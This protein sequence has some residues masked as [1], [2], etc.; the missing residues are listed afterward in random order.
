MKKSKIYKITAK[1]LGREANL[2]DWEQLSAL[3][4]EGKNASSF[5]DFVKIQYLTK[6]S[7]AHYDIKNA[8]KT[9]NRKLKK[10]ERIRS[11]YKKMT[12]AAVIAIIFGISFYKLTT[13]QEKGVLDASTTKVIEIDPGSNKAILTL[14]NGN[15]VVLEKGKEYTSKKMKSNGTELKYVP[16]NNAVNHKEKPIYNFLTVPKGGQFFV[17]LSDGTSVWLNSDSKLKYP[18]EFV[19]GEKRIVE[20]VYGEA[21]FKVSPS[22]QHQGA[23]FSVINNSHEVSVLGTEFNMKVYTNDDTAL[24]TLVEG[25]VKI[26]KDGSEKI[27]NPD[28]QARI[29]RLSN[30]VEVVKVDASRETSWIRGLFTFDEEPLEDIM[31]TLSRWYNIEVV[32]ESSTKRKL[33]FTGVLERAEAIT[34]ILKLIEDTSMRKVKF[35]IKN[36]TIII[37]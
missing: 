32:F 26:H 18:E 24:T 20:L 31:K 16:A 12:M 21:Y 11:L 6:I 23:S 22:T 35:E 37:K 33:I 10:K 34:E 25:K 7:M 28:Q 15:E 8:K 36:K 13:G 5:I 17:Q 3:L 30:T 19:E 14:G 29:E 1:F 2:D 9:I 4:K 27:L